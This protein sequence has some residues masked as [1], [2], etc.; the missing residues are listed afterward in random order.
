M[1]PLFKSLKLLDSQRVVDFLAENDLLRVNGFDGSVV[2]SLPRL[3]SWMSMPPKPEILS[4]GDKMFSPN[5]KLIKGSRPPRGMCPEVRGKRTARPPL[6]HQGIISGG[7][8]RVFE[9]VA[10][11]LVA[12][13]A[14]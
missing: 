1:E 5:A 13:D 6:R 10:Q 3:T 14:S 12:V 7:N 11:T 2:H 9:N 8:L 4:S